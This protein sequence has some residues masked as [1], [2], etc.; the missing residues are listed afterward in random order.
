MPNSIAPY[1]LLLN[2]ILKPRVWGGRRLE[3]LG[4]A[5]PPGENVGESWEVADLPESIENGR[6]I[7]INGP[8]AGLTLREAMDRD[9]KTILGRA[10]RTPEGGF[11]LLIKFLDARENLSV[12]V[13]PDENYARKHPEAQLKSEAW[14]IID[15]D[16]PGLIYRGVKPHV[17]R[18]EF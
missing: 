2:P 8:L 17:T 7:I 14:V 18:Q 4:K 3:S 12:Q 15:V 16:P 13:H 10:R 1:P 11:P 9:E 5:L 6:N